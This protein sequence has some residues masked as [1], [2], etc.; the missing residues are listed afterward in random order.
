MADVA[1]VSE[2]HLD[3]IKLLIKPDARK[4]HGVMSNWLKRNISIDK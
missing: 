4:E 3:H 2:E 1:L